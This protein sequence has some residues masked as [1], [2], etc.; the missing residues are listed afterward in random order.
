MQ[1]PGLSGYRDAAALSQRF[2]AP[3]VGFEAR[4]IPRRESNQAERRARCVRGEPPLVNLSE[5]VQHGSDLDKWRVVYVPERV[6]VQRMA[7]LIDPRRPDEFS[8]LLFSDWLLGIG[9][10]RAA[11]TVVVDR[12]VGPDEGLRFR[13]HPDADP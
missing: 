5:L 1:V 13:H 9:T 6:A 10:Y 11:P 4:S 2:L 7:R 3:R 8:S 12:P